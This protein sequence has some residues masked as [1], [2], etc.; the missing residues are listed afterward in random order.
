MMPAHA[1][2]QG[3]PA[4]RATVLLADDHAIVVEGLTRLLER[5]FTLVGTVTDGARL[6]DAARQRRPDV[7]VTDV[8]M[9][10]MGGLEAL[11]RLKAE[12]ISAKVIF[13]TMHADAQLATE[14]L[15][16]GA[17]GFVVKHAAGAD[18][19]AAIHAVLRGGTY[20]APQLAPDVL[21]RLAEGHTRGDGR[22]T[23]RQRDVASLIAAGR[24]LKEIGTALG[25]SPRTV[26]THKYQ[27]MAALGLRT[28]A[29]LIRYA[30]E[31]GLAGPAD[32]P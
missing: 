15:R 1:E 32:Q 17:S 12:Q 19:I 16:V 14:A 2:G 5:E 3:Q 25:L 27:I 8:A 21:A 29:E 24:T 31:H 28:T 4:C 11:H 6:I 22:L 10:G 9:P 7:I 18:L 30:L 23:P 20:V 26:E 13:L